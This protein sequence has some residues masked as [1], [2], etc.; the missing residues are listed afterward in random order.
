MIIDNAGL[1][2]ESLGGNVAVITDAA[3][4]IGR[5]TALALAHISTAVVAATPDV[6]SGSA[7]V[8]LIKKRGGSAAYIQ[9]DTKDLEQADRFYLEAKKAFGKV[10]ILVVTNSTCAGAGLFLTEMLERRYG[11]V[12][13]LGRFSQH[14]TGMPASESDRPPLI[15]AYIQRAG[16]D[17]RVAVFSFDIGGGS[18]ELAAAGLVG[19]IRF[20]SEFHG[21]NID[22]VT[23]LAKLKLDAEGQQIPVIE[24]EV[25]MSGPA[26]GSPSAIAQAL[27][28]VMAGLDDEY[29]DL[30][31]L[32]RAVAKR[33]FQQATGLKVD[34]WRAYAVEITQKLIGGTSGEAISDT[35]LEN[36]GKLRE[37]FTKQET[38]VNQWFKD[39]DELVAALDE[40]TYRKQV[41]VDLM[42]A[43]KQ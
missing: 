25:E 35:D 14:E 11:I 28:E 34:E 15:E 16:S 38:E 2:P 10:D 32:V 42:I 22:Y 41:V 31:I 19:A 37:F 24:N 30:S 29:D 23:G 6:E 20:G 9:V 12:V 21:K 13:F 4:G 39:P 27:E 5:E 26:S 43:L 3:S 8:G 40:L 17:G 1:D 33:S 7:I 36:L 18:D